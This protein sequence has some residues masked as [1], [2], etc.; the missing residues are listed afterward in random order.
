MKTETTKRID[1]LTKWTKITN[2]SELAQWLQPRHTGLPWGPGSQAFDELGLW[3]SPG[4]N[5]NVSIFV[6][7]LV[8][9]TNPSEK[10][11][12]WSVGMIFH[13][14]YMKSQKNKKCSKPPTSYICVLFLLLHP[15]LPFLLLVFVGA[16]LTLEACPAVKYYSS[17]ELKAPVERAKDLVF[18]GERVILKLISLLKNNHFPL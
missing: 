8:V 18:S 15:S 10:W 11:W 13:S 5:C 17:S 9:S 6:S 7:W 2:S 1:P 16:C 3:P 12:S 4:R 14:Q